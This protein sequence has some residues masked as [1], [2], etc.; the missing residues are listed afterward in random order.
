MSAV[1]LFLGG[2]HHILSVNA[3]HAAFADGGFDGYVAA[4]QGGRGG[5]AGQGVGQ[6]NAVGAEQ[7]DVYEYFSVIVAWEQRTEH[8]VNQSARQDFVVRGAAFTFGETAGEASGSGIL[9]AVVALQR[10]EIGSRHC[11]LRSAHCGQQHGV[12]QAQDGASV[13]LFGHLACLD[14]DDA[15]V[16]QLDS[17]C[18]YIHLLVNL[19]LLLLKRLKCAQRY[20]FFTD[21]A[22]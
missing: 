6:V 9:L 16:R 5:K 15:A 1:E 8:A 14:A 10:H 22:L 18:N 4:C 7:H 20:I 12:V 17:L 19:K 21:G 2:V 3:G 11:I 13:G